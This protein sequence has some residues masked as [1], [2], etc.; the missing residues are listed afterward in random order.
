M[1]E[2]PLF[3]WL[4]SVNIL[5]FFF[6]G[7]VMLAVF[8]YV[9]YYM[10]RDISRER[11]VYN[12]VRQEQTSDVEVKV[13]LSNFKPLSGTP[14][15]MAPIGSQQNYRHSYYDKSANSIRNYL[16]FN[17][18][19]KSAKKLLTKNDFLFLNA[20]N[21]V[22]RNT[23]TNINK[24]N[25]IWYTLVIEDTNND[26]RLDSRDKKTIAVSDVSGNGYT[27]VI[28]KIDR[29]IGSHQKNQN[30]VLIFYES[31]GKNLFS[32]ID[33]VQRRSVTE[34]NLPALD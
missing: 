27:E 20:N 8:G 32:E 9:G 15:L 22:E 7:L 17:G 6:L 31:G 12:S 25:G 3:R 4:K 11:N 13:S 24:V 26:K 2:S 5:L 28:K 34:Q 14:Y 29:V 19:D 18:N 21:V 33:V 23:Q 16:F 10:F 1:S 30:T